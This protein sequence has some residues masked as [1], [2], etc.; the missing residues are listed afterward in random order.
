MRK[1]HIYVACLRDKRSAYA[2]E[3]EIMLAMHG[4]R[5]IAVTPDTV[6]FDWEMENRIPLNG[7]VASCEILVCIDG[8]FE[9]EK[10]AKLHNVPVFHIGSKDS[11]S[12]E[13]LACAEY[14][15]K[16]LQ[17]PES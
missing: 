17:N 4:I 3:L 7:L 8:H 11:T 1:V 10:E 13:F 15:K 14:C 6:D 16:L 5:A 9:E 12:V 2:N